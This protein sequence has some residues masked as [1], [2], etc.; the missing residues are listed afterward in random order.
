MLGMELIWA[1]WK[2]SGFGSLSGSLAAMQMYIYIYLG[3]IWGATHSG[4]AQ[5]IILGEWGMQCQLKM[6]ARFYSGWIEAICLDCRIKSLFY[7]LSIL[8]WLDHAVWSTCISIKNKKNQ[9]I[10]LMMPVLSTVTSP[11]FIVF[12]Q[13]GGRGHIALWRDLN[14]WLPL[15]VTLINGSTTAHLQNVEDIQFLATVV[16]GT[17]ADLLG[18]DCHL[19]L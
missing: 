10:H 11:P 12:I 16:N 1:E 6:D 15:E 19:C 4:S 14:G 8:I 9:E 18:G 2:K 17:T 13:A 3:A 5:N 7:L